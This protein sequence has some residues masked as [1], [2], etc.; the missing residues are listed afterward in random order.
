[1]TEQQRVSRRIVFT[2]ALAGCG[3]LALAGC[4]GSESGTASGSASGSASS[5]GGGSVAQPG[6]ALGSTADIPVGG[7]AIFPDQRVVVT[8]PTEGTFEGFSAACTHQ[9]QTVTGVTDGTIEC[10]HHGSRFD[11]A[12]GEV[13]GGPARN[14]LPRVEIRVEGD[15]IFVA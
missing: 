2:G 9:G 12:S 13:T 8:Q 10:N 14:P 3:L 15:Q 6:E 1:M 7:G 5:G 11:A 4:G